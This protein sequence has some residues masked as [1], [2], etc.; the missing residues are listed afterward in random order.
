MFTGETLRLLRNAKGMKQKT[1]ADKLRISQPAYSKL[2][3]RANINGH[4]LDRLKT[5]FKCS[6]S[7]IEVIQKLLQPYKMD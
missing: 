1:V 7:E 2:E 4:T 6:D 3:K 5:I